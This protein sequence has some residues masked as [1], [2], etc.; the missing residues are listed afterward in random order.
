MLYNQYRPMHDK[1]NT[2]YGKV[3]GGL[4][5]LAPA[6]LL[7]YSKTKKNVVGGGVQS[8]RIGR[9]SSSNGGGLNS[10]SSSK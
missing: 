9:C 7:S 6:A 5:Q 4:P 1:P 8:M 2:Q 3:I 10:C